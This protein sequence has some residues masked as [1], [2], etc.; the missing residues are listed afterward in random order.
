MAN[1]GTIT[2]DAGSSKY[3]GGVLASNG[4]IYGIPYSSTKVLAIDTSLP[5]Y[6]NWMIKAYFNKL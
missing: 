1:T 5:I 4:K 3:F 2:V 6:P